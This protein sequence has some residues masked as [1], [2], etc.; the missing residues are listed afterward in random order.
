MGQNYLQVKKGENETGAKI[1]LYTVHYRPVIKIGI[2]NFRNNIPQNIPYCQY[3][4]F[5]MNDS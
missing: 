4:K 3:V 1:T 5:N 2:N